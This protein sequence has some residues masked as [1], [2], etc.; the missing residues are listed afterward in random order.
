L[1]SC[2][3]AKNKAATTV[4]IQEREDVE[5][6]SEKVVV[7]GLWFGGMGGFDQ[8]RCLLK[9][10]QGSSSH[11]QQSTTKSCSSRGGG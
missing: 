9:I 2:S 1:K 11:S 3:I 8:P 10:L 5:T 4:N 6:W 7:V